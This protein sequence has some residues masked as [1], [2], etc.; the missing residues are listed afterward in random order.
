MTGIHFVYTKLIVSGTMMHLSDSERIAAKIEGRI[1][2]SLSAWDV[3]DDRTI[4][5]IPESDLY[6]VEKLI[7][8]TRSFAIEPILAS[9]LERIRGDRETITIKAYCEVKL[10][11]YNLIDSVEVVASESSENWQRGIYRHRLTG[12]AIIRKGEHPEYYI[13]GDR[14]EPFDWIYQREDT[15]QAACEYIQQTGKEYVIQTLIREGA[16]QVSETFK[17]NI[18]IIG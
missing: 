12:P 11:D 10:E 7:D 17:S 14:V 3:T 2:V 15:E 18:Q 6:H 9:I 8:P 13:Y 4:I 5:P 1:K 16:I